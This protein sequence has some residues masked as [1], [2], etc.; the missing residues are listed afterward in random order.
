MIIGGVVGFS[1]A[2]EN[3]V[4]P[5]VVVIVGVLVM[6]ILRRTIKEVYADERTYTIAHK[7]SRLTIAIIA[8]IMP[9]TGAVL[10]ALSH[11]NLSSARAQVGFALEYITCGLLI[12]QY[13]AYYYY[14]RKLGGR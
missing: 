2:S 4:A 10:L 14:S 1:V 8:I 5:I 3:W 6:L 9:V 13:I 7:A 11:H 12:I